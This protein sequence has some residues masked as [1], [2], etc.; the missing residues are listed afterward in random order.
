MNYAISKAEWKRNER[1]TDAEVKKRVLDKYG[2]LCCERCG[3]TGDN[4]G[5][6]ISHT[7]AKGMGGTRRLYTAEDKQLLCATR[8]NT[9]A[10]LHN[11]REVKA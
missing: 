10:D 11:L 4:R 3:L 5:L 7:D 9:S 2:Y 6:A 8:H 1:K